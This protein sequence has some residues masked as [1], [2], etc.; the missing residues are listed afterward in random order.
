MDGLS[1]TGESQWNLTARQ[2]NPQYA[3]SPDL[4]TGRNAENKFSG[5]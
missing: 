2:L 3:L 5:P 1:L 4:Y